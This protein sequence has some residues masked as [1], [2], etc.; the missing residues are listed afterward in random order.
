MCILIINVKN[1][2]KRECMYYNK[3]TQTNKLNQLTKK[4]KTNL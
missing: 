4:P 2:L 3:R 1:I